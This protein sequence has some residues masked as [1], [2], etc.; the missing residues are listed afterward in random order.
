M[1]TST[2]ATAS[3]PCGPTKSGKTVLIKSLVRAGDDGVYLSGGL[4]SSVD[5]LW[6]AIADELGVFTA[7]SVSDEQEEVAGRESGG[8]G[9][10]NFALAGK[11]GRKSIESLASRRGTSRGRE[12][13]AVYAAREALRS[14]DKGSRDR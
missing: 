10:L 6:S 7:E 4:I 2:S 12:R 5:G 8:E 11:W 14:S 13:P 1:T 9:G 3:C